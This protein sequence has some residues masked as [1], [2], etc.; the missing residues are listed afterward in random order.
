MRFST[1]PDSIAN[2]M[3]WAS[4]L[5]FLALVPSNTNLSYACGIQHP[6]LM[7]PLLKQVIGV[8]TLSACFESDD[9]WLRR[10]SQSRFQLRQASYRNAA[11]HHTLLDFAKRYMA[12]AQIQ[13]YTTYGQSPLDPQ[14]SGILCLWR[15]TQLATS[16]AA[17]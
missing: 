8:P 4:I 11:N 9:C 17:R 5:S 12:N 6:R 2:A 13:S 15:L 7:P 14:P 1:R 16:S 3:T 10:W